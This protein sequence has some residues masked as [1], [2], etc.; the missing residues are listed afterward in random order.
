M[1]SFEF[2]T[3]SQQLKSVPTNERNLRRSLLRGSSE[4]EREPVDRSKFFTNDAELDTAVNGLTTLFVDEDAPADSRG[5]LN[6]PS[7]L[8]EPGDELY[9]GDIQAIVASNKPI[10]T[11][12]D[13]MVANARSQRKNQAHSED[14]WDRFSDEENFTHNVFQ[15]DPTE[16]I[17]IG[18]DQI[19]PVTV[20]NFGEKLRK[21]HIESVIGAVAA[22]SVMTDGYTRALTP[23]IVIHDAFKSEYFEQ[24]QSFDKAAGRAWMG[25]PFIEARRS[26]FDSSSTGSVGQS[27]VSQLIGHEISHQID[28]EASANY[29]DFNSYFH[30]IDTNRDG[31]IDYVKPRSSFASDYEEHHINSSRPVRQ[32]GFTN[33]TE[34][35]AT[36]GEELPFGGDVDQLR[37]D[38]Y[39][40]V[41]EA[42]KEKSFKKHGEMQPLPEQLKV[43]ITRGGEIN[44]PVATSLSTPIR[45]RVENDGIGRVNNFFKQ[46]FR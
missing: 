24:S 17:T 28:E 27:W 39:M 30:Y 20:Y 29:P 14:W 41:I 43:E 25:E 26:S 35:L 33:S 12:L 45:I 31:L 9:Y 42:F 40:K 19:E 5:I 15:G 34:D 8:I 32:Y 18:R 22:M 37:K 38:A 23:Y 21:R 4:L 7:S 11:R 1:Q 46:L 10:G 2:N 36:V 3:H 44:L 13:R 6:A 16:Q